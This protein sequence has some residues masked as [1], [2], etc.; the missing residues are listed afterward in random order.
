MFA[1]A[2]KPGVCSVTIRPTTTGSRQLP[3]WRHRYLTEVNLAALTAYGIYDW[4]EGWAYQTGFVQVLCTTV[5]LEEC[6]AFS[7]Y[8]RADHSAV[9]T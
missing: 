9:Y 4:Q 2:K 6:D 7:S 3:R 8:D 1:R 5:W